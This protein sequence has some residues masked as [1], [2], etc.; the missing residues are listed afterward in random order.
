MSDYNRDKVVTSTPSIVPPRFA[1]TS[2]GRLAQE[3]GHW[4]GE[5][6]VTKEELCGRRNS[7]AHPARQGEQRPGLRRGGGLGVGPFGP[8]FGR[9]EPQRSQQHA[10]VRRHGGQGHGP[11]RPGVLCATVG[12]ERPHH[13]QPGGTRIQRGEVR[14]LRP[15]REAIPYLIRRARKHVRRG[16]NASRTRVAQARAT[17]GKVESNSTVAPVRNAWGMAG[18]NVGRRATT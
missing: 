15:I 17:G 4:P 18:R 1:T 7:T 5:A 14:P 2:C 8:A 16:P 9:G 10:A 12:H 13:L 3:V 6:R 11:S